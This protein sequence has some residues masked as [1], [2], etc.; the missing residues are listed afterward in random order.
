MLEGIIVGKDLKDTFDGI[1][2]DYEEARP[3]YPKD[4]IRDIVKI[5][6][7]NN[8][9]RILEVGCGTGQATE[10]FISLG[11]SVTGIELGNK[12]SDF[13][14]VKFKDYSNLKV[15][16]NAFEEWQDEASSYDLI[17]SATAF[18]WIKPEIG[19]PKAHRLLKDTGTIAFF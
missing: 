2:L 10:H 19:Y 16:N 11:Y 7:I 13:L 12:L 18:H 1:V 8:G 4:L 14:K 3:G 15:Y 6:K 17:I 9:S 5:S